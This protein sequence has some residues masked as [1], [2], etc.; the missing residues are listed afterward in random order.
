MMKK[1]REKE[2][3]AE[4]FDQQL[5]KLRSIVDKMEHG[6]LSLEE[7]LKLFE[8]GIGL[9]S[10]LFEILSRAEGKVEELLATMERVPFSNDS[11]IA[12]A[13]AA[14]SLELNAFLPLIADC[15][16]ETLDVLARADD[17]LARLC[18]DGIE[19]DEARCRAHV[20]NA[21]TE[22]TELVPRLGYERA[23]EA[24][25]LA[26][27]QGKTLRDVVVELGWMS[28]QEFDEATS[29]E[30]VCRLGSPVRKDAEAPGLKPIK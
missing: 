20:M 9:S 1:A 4:H 2:E 25:R 7:S 19:A 29:P 28:A 24:E 13:C 15:L 8:E 5:E 23:E 21:T 26:R 6:G 22:A 12:A 3:G 17:L 11:V 30:A 16:L 14:G 27:E 10:S 18:V